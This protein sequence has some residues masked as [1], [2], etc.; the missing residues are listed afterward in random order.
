MEHAVGDDPVQYPGIG[1]VLS[2]NFFK[3]TTFGSSVSLHASSPL[4]SLLCLLLFRDAVPDS[5]PKLWCLISSS[6][7]ASSEYSGKLAKLSG[8]TTTWYVPGELAS[9]FSS[10]SM[11]EVNDA[12]GGSESPPAGE[13]GLLG[14]RFGDVA[15]ALN[16]PTEAVT[17]ER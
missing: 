1:G 6:S 12:K 14:V 8:L 11:S 10:R 15:T 4:R 17:S 2:S 9:A 5:P 3:I 16:Q 13:P 7:S